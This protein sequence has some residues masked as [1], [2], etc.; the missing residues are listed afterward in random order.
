MTRDKGVQGVSPW[1]GLGFGDRA[2][3]RPLPSG[4]R[5][6]APLFPPQTRPWR[7]KTGAEAPDSA[8]ARSKTG[9]PPQTRPGEGPPGPCPGPTRGQG[10]GRPLEPRAAVWAAENSPSAQTLGGPVMGRPLTGRKRKT[11]GHAEIFLLPELYLYRSEE[12]KTEKVQPDLRPG[13]NNS[14]CL[15]SVFGRTP[16]PGRMF[17]PLGEFRPGGRKARGPGAAAPAGVGV[18][19]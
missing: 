6:G 5:G 10:A 18:W 3:A 4:A 1:R 13:L 16:E 9:A 19:G 2:P 8:R 15:L 14:S 12:K 7:S 17:E 11:A